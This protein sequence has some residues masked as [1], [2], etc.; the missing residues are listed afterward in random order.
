MIF[1]PRT[2]SMRKRC[3][4]EKNGEGEGIGENNGPLREGGEVPPIRENDQFFPTKEIAKRKSVQNTL[5][6]VIK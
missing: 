2:P 3:D 1:D 4:R 5:K 6:H